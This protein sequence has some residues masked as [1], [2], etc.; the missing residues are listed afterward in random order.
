[1]AFLAL[2]LVRRLRVALLDVVGWPR[3]V[4][5]FE[6]RRGPRL[7]P[8]APSLVVGVHICFARRLAFDCVD[9]RPFVV[10]AL[11]RVV[12]SLADR[13][14]LLVVR[15]RAQ[16]LEPPVV[17]AVFDV[18]A[19][20]ANLVV[21]AERDEPS[22]RHRDDVAVL[23]V[24]LVRT[25]VLLVLAAVPQVE[26]SAQRPLLLGLVAASVLVLPVPP[27]LVLVAPVKVRDEVVRRVPAVQEA[28]GPRAVAALVAPLLRLGL[29]PNAFVLLV[30]AH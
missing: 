17:A 16:T 1:M 19:L 26:K 15:H 30:L 21:Q 18:R 23:T 28:D 2:L 8:V 24:T 27:A 12:H 4:V 14:P 22:L 13:L 29:L 6:P 11:A 25:P 3:L 20:L 10:L 7:G 9:Y 5:V